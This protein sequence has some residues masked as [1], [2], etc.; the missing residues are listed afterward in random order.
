M[1]RSSTSFEPG[2]S[3]NPG[4]RPKGLAEVQQLAR[5]HA[6][7]AVRTLA[8]IMRSRAS[9]DRARIAA[10]VALLDRGFG[11]PSPS[12]LLERLERLEQTLAERN[13]HN[14]S[15]RWGT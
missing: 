12:D 11:K 7:A 14:G 2:Q 15:G 4:G 9:D 3:G 6:P 8:R 13:G 10:A 1:A 5:E